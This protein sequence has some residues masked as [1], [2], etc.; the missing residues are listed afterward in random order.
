[1]NDKEL[2]VVGNIHEKLPYALIFSPEALTDAVELTGSE[3][4]VTDVQSGSPVFSPETIQK[5]QE[6]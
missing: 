6:K 5:M 4:Q 2:E 1:M 3:V